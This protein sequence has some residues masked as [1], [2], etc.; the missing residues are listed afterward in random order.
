MQIQKNRTGVD[1]SKFL[2]KVDLASWKSE[3]DQLGI[4]K[5]EKIPTGLIC[6]KNKVDKLDVHKLVPVLV[7]FS[8]LSD[9]LNLNATINE[10]SNE[11]PNITN[12]VINASVD[13]NINGVKS[14]RYYYCT[15]CY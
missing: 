4:D 15:Y 8:K 7:D 10:V 14:N 12:L 11:T 1:A 9:V 2:E 3:V 13:A 6:F 5:S